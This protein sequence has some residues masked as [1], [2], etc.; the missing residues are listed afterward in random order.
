MP[1][2]FIKLEELITEGDLKTASLL[3]KE[4]T[5]IIF[6][7]FDTSCLMSACKKLVSMRGYEIGGTRAP[8]L[9]LSDADEPIVRELYDRIIK[10]G[11]RFGVKKR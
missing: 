4:I 2:L 6:R 7:M 8:F 3:Q 1:E 10:V 5:G 11:D 9:P